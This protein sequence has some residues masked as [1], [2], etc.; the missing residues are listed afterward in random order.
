[1]ARWTS[2]RTSAALVVPT[3]LALLAPVAAVAE[4]TTTEDPVEAAAGWLA[5]QLVDDER[6]E[7]T[8]DFGDGPQTFPDQGLT[9]D[10]VYALAGAGVAADHIASAT[11]WL[12]EQT[13]AYTGT[14][15]GDV[16]AGSVAKLLLV[17]ATTD[18]SPTDFGDADLVTLL[19]DREQESGRFTD[20][21][22]GDFSS[23]ITQSLAVLAL[24][25]TDDTDPSAT[26]VEY[27]ADQACDDGSFPQQLETGE[28]TGEID[29]TAFAV[30]ALTVV[31]ETEAAGEAAAWL[32]DTQEDDGGFIGSEGTANA[33]STGLAAI[34][35]AEGGESEAA[36]KAQE[37][38]AGLQSGCD[39]PEPGSIRYDAEDGGD[40]VRAT[41]QALPGLTGVGLAT[42]SADGATTD[43]PR[44]DCPPTFSDVSPDSVHAEAIEELAR[45]DILL[46]RDDG[47]FR[48]AN[49]VTRGQLASIV[50]R[51]AGFPDA[52]G[53]DFSDVEGSTH[54]GAIYAL[55]ERG[56]ARGYDDGTFRPGGSIQRDQAAAL[57]ARW[58]ELTPV[59]EDAFT[60][61]DRTIH[62]GDIN[63]LAEVDVARGTEDDRFLPTRS[64]RRDQT[65]S[66][67]YRALQLVERDG[68]DAAAAGR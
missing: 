14:D 65:A 28:C 21:T 47:T 61:L 43:L 9:A 20:D 51:T 1:L 62:R 6:I 57:L 32:V 23:V 67:V 38:L 3:T 49:D 37:F 31:G 58:L 48:P 10:V 5:D 4:P 25:R 50:A 36:A 12:E 52:E 64:I 27:L 7:V 35:L 18:R 29:A 8:F 30:Q 15:F 40:P 34:A 2:R 39:G 16:Y 26:A 56:I 66:L 45:R 13:G 54:E 60:D 46:G 22:D 63:A 33:N 53:D 19:E 17:A 11:D 24:E 41:A 55:A 59:D 44:F 42:V 68:D